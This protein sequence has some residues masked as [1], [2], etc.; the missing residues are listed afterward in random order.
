MIFRR[1]VPM[2]K[3]HRDIQWTSLVRYSQVIS[4]GIGF[5]LRCSLDG[6]LEFNAPLNQEQRDAC[7]ALLQAMASDNVP[8]AP[9]WD[10][11]AVAPNPEPEEDEEDEDQAV[12]EPAEDLHV[13]FQEQV[14]VDTAP[15][16]TLSASKR[17]FL[18]PIVQPVLTRLFISLATHLPS[19]AADGKWFNLFLPFVVLASIREKGEFILSGQI[20]QI[21]AAILFLLRLVMFNIMDI[22]VINNPTERYEAY[23]FLSICIDCC[24]DCISARFDT[25]KNI[26]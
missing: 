4:R 3:F 5:A 12:D 15:S 7:A 23:V 1:H 13:L 16:D 18:C 21:I 17:T 19:T 20:T 25:S 22:H 11:D 14:R 9:P 6:D 8:D 2:A 10:G 24:T 26:F